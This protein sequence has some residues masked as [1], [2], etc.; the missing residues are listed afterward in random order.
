M[1]D[2]QTPLSPP[3]LTDAFGRTVSYLSLIHI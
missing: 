2:G 3:P 1:P